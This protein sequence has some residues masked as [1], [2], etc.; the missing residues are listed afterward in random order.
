MAKFSCQ[1]VNSTYRMSSGGSNDDSLIFVS[2][3]QGSLQRCATGLNNGESKLE[4]G[5]DS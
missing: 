5:K 3:S 1:R 4:V 2:S